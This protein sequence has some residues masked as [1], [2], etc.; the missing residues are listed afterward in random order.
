VSKE[1]EEVL[2]VGNVFEFQ[3]GLTE[4]LKIRPSTTDK[5]RIHHAPE[6]SRRAFGDHRSCKQFLQLKTN[7]QKGSMSVCFFHQKTK[8]EKKGDGGDERPLCESP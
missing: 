6:L 3:E 7:K 5:V 4:L 1:L 2:T 8:S